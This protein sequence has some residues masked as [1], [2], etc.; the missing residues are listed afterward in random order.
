[1]NLMP[2]AIS[3]CLGRFE[4][5]LVNTRAIFLTGDGSRTVRRTESRLQFGKQL[6]LAALSSLILAGCAET[7][8]VVHAAKEVINRQTPDKKTASTP[9]TDDAAKAASNAKVGPGG[10]YKIGKPYQVA[11]VWYHPKVEPSYNSTGIASW[12]GK[13]FHGR[14]TANGEIYDMNTLTAAHKTLPL[15]TNVRVTNLENGR[16]IVLRV[17]DRGPFVNGRIIDVS[18]RGAHLLGFLRQGTAKVRVEIVGGPSNRGRVIARANTSA[19]ERNAVKAVPQGKVQVAQL[20]PPP[21]V[22]AAPKQVVRAGKSAGPVTQTK[23][24]KDPLMYIQAGAF[25][26]YE[27][28]LKLSATLD[29]VGETKI[30][31]VI[32]DGTEFFRVRIGPLASVN[33]ADNT[34]GWVIDNGYTAARIVIE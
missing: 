33:Q 25:T 4:G 9:A 12:Y 19:E 27:N 13:P 3:W 28:A 26:I 30:T 16:S 8:L 2:D 5:N 21:G 7:Q 15:P 11:G 20:A 34:L 32:V 23:V 10:V 31:S 17:N 6:F 18:R 22:E 29:S 14:K 24:A 1:M